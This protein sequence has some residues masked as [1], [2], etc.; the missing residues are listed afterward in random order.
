MIP[1]LFTLKYLN[2]KFYM[3]CNFFKESFADDNHFYDVLMQ[4][5]RVIL[6][7]TWSEQASFAKHRI[8]IEIAN[9]FFKSGVHIGNAKSKFEPFIIKDGPDLSPAFAPDSPP[10]FAPE[11]PP[12]SPPGSPPA[13]PPGPLP[14]SP[15]ESPP[16]SRDNPRRL[17]LSH[18]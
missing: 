2:N 3:K 18:P 5:S 15:P 13:S 7:T 9:S 10:T 16:T 4:Q 17:L 8:E 14:T 1:K 12:A 11:S 6:N